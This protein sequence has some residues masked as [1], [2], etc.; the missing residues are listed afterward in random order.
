[1]YDHRKNFT[2][3]NNAIVHPKVMEALQRANT[4]HCI[5]YGD[6][7]YTEAARTKFRS[8][9]GDE[10]ETYFVYN[11]TG[12]NVTSL[13]AAAAPFQ[14]VIC[15]EKAHINVDE[16]GAV[17]RF[18]G[19]R[20]LTV[21]TEDGK[22]TPDL[23]KPFL[24]VLGVEHHS[25][26]AVLSITQSTEV[27]TVYTLKELKELTDFAH[28]MGLTVH[29]D[30]ARIANAAASLGVSLKAMTTDSGIDI[31][32]FGGTK[33][34]LMFGEA[35]VI[36]NKRLA[37][38]YK[39]ARKQAAQL[40]SKMR[41]IAAQFD[42]LLT[43]DLWLYNAKQANAMAA[44]LAR[45]ISSIPGI[46]IVYP[47]QANALFVKLPKDAAARLMEKYL[48]Y[49]WDKEAG[50]YRWMTSFDMVEEDIYDFIEAV[51]AVL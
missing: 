37:E 45:E 11:G 40:A 3:D 46:E 51:K 49:P 18:I 30:G 47:V 1:M 39:Y 2:S 4:G 36:L 7:P 35:V 34:G 50:V 14:A 43:D 19:C 23:V 10:S 15:P 22:L 41:Y 24:N 42:A 17:Q 48:F 27:G 28:S 32:S 20:L 9:F 6:D 38:S 44:L 13:A 31:L 8:V 12:A 5:S 21:K 16:C 26:P 33:N 29:M 25:Q